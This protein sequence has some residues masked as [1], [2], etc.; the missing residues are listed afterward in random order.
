MNKLTEFKLVNDDFDIEFRIFPVDDEPINIDLQGQAIA[1]ELEEI[2]EAISL[3]QCKLEDLNKD[4]N[5]LTNNADGLDYV[6]AVISG[7]LAG[8]IDSLWVGEFKFERGKAWSNHTINDF[9]LKVAQKQGYEG[10]RLAGAIKFLEDRFHIPSDNIWK[11]KDIG[12]SAK[13]H[14]LDDFAHHP[15]PLGLFFSIL[16]QFTQNGCFQNGDGEFLP[17]SIDEAGEGL[18]GNDIPSK[19]FAGTVNWFFH[20]VSDMSGSNKTAGVGMGIPGPI[21]SL[22]KEMSMIPGLDKTELA[23]L[24]QK[25]FCKERFDLRS[26]LAVCHELVRQA[27][28]VILSEGIVRAFYF[29]RPLITEA[30]EKK[31]F[32]NIDLENTLPWKSRTIVRMITIATGTFTVIDLFDAAKRSGWT[33]NN[34]FL[35]RVNFVGVGRFTIAVGSDIKMGLKES[36]LRYE[37]IS[38]LS[39]Q[40]HLMN[41]RV[42]YS[43]AGSWIAAE[44]T[45]KTIKEAVD[46]MEKAMSLYFLTLQSNSKSLEN[47]GQ[48]AQSVE[49]NNPGLIEDINDVLKWR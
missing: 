39:E 41:A 11:G 18:I 10:D 17:I 48:Y 28:P 22:A 27:V 13:S 45:E 49:Q 20:L 12:I 9:V 7:I 30:I 33:F 8:L 19:I 4:I 38:V 40:L 15:T 1:V 24:I 29:L 26:E 31:S 5:L 16:T 35:L 43:Q 21:L 14:H 23:K 44:T 46:R 3:N 36:K 6:V 47:I 34:E 32:K 37:Q 25:W 2:N 42:F